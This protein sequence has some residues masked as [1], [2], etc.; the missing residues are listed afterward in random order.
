MKVSAVVPCYNESGNVKEITERLLPFVDEIVFVDD[1]SDDNTLE[2][3][4]SL[5]K[6]NIIIVSHEKNMG[7]GAALKT[8]FSKASGD[9]ILTID[10]DMTYPPEYAKRIIGM[11]EGFDLVV[12]S[13]FSQ[14][15]PKNL[16][17]AR[18]VSNILGSGFMSVLLGKRITD[19][20]SGMRVFRRS[21]LS[22]DIKAE[23][24]N[25]EVEQT[26]LAVR[27]GL[28]YAEIPIVPEPRKGKSKLR[29]GKDLLLFTATI[30]SA[31]F[32]KMRI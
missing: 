4:E 16:D 30:L 8:G 20:T 22:L 18:I 31:R 11:L 15:I 32:R 27:K 23:G 29:F 25:F 7:K 5:K 10:A 13:R 14:G 28:R 17:I 24:L 6:N 1:G 12:A 21:L 26:T 9:V 3:M 19:G 2:E